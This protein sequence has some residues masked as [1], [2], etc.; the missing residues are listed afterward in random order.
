M[1]GGEWVATALGDSKLELSFCF[2]ASHSPLPIF[3]IQYLIANT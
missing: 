1:Q 2:D 3:D